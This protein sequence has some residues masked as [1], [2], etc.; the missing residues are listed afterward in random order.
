MKAMN[1]I[2][3]YGYEPKLTYAAWNDKFPQEKV[4]FENEDYL[5]HFDGI[6][7]NSVELKS[8]L[9]CGSNQELL[10]QLYRSHGAEL[11][12]YAKGCYALVIWDKQAQKLLITNDLLSKRTF[13]YCMTEQSLCYGSSYHDLL[14]IL[15]S[16]GHSPELD[17][18]AMNDVLLR[19]FVNGSKTY[20]RQAAYLNAFESLVVDLKAG[21][22]QLVQHAMK[23]VEIPDSEEAIIDKFDALF[24]NA[25]KLQC[26]KNAEYGY[27]Q[28]ATLS[29]GMDSRACLLV[30]NKLGYKKDIV[31]F[32][33]AQSG[34]LDYSISQ[35]IAAD[36]GLDYVFYPM[37]AAVFLGRL[38]DAMSL[39]ECMQSGIGATGA[40]TMAT[41]LNTSNFGLI[42]IGICGGELMGDLIQRNRGKESSN[43]VLRMAVRILKKL[44][45]ELIPEEIKAENYRF[46]LQEY[47]CHLRAS[48]NF[49]HMFIDKCECISPFM[50]EDV[51]TFVLQLNPGLL[52]NRRIYRKWMIKYHPNSYII[53]S[54]CSTI[55]ATLLQELSAKLKYQVLRKRNGISQWDMNP[56]NR[57]LETQPHHAQE[58][59]REF[60]E[61]CQ[62]LSQID[63]TEDL[64]HAVQKSWD[65]PWLKRLYVLTCL[66]ALKD[67]HSRFGKLS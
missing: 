48:Q 6:I 3:R 52:Y 27:T 62:W 20:L 36:L 60:E 23:A 57:W 15:S 11:V 67:I 25:V 29:G 14:D 24:S 51:A 32:N 2:I 58:C 56:V 21:I 49:T 13:Y 19:G 35:Q 38:H 66:Q 12:F 18:D 26:R 42:S 10:L 34:S 7:L 47:L 53:T 31:C 33:Y 64:L 37:D 46:N 61:G 55:D 22:T 44:K 45:S 54:T 8:E 30:A 5:I 43:K 65:N 17:A 1:G 16:E 9:Q 39:N 40:R 50:D 59:L 63:G 4:N 28:C 41:V